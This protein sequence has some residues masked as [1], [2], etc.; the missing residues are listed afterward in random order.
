MLLT[1]RWQEVPF[2][3]EL[4]RHLQSTPL[5]IFQSFVQTLEGILL[6]LPPTYHFD[7][8]LLYKLRSACRSVNGWE[9]A[10]H[11]RHETSAT[12][13]GDVEPALTTVGLY[14]TPASSL[15]THITYAEL[16]STDA[17]FADRSFVG[18]P[19]PATKPGFP[20]HPRSRS[21]D[22]DGWRRSRTPD[23]SK[24]FRSRTP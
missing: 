13:L 4:A 14:L 11:V 21:R 9:L 2:S 16:T 24:Q 6:N 10:C 1:Q 3:K 18:T 23:R 7:E 8:F 15:T 12:F 22:D 5:A 20:Y 19:A 17:Y